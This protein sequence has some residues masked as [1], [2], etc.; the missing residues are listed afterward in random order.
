M[1]KVR[2]KSSSAGVVTE[3]SWYCPG[4]QCSHYVEIKPHH[5]SKGQSWTW[6]EDIGEPVIKPSVHYVG[7]CHC[8]VGG[9]SGEVPGKIVF[10]S[11]CTHA[12]AGQTV[13]TEDVEING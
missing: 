11:D 8:Y 6:N 10:L 13:E 3:V 5:G 12:L 1:N 2:I 9:V 7:T 4:C